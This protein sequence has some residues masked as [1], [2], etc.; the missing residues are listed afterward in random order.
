MT[1]IVMTMN[2][3]ELL[4]YFSLRL[5]TRAQKEHR[6]LAEKMLAICKKVS[7]TIFKNAG[8]SCVRD[9]FCREQRSCGRAPKLERVIEIMDEMEY[10]ASIRD[11]QRTAERECH[12]CIID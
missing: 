10:E 8:P 12:R 4:H 3:R 6:E 7:P 2:A 1:N 9:G 5:C 11:E